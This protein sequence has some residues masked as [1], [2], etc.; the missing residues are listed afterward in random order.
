MDNFDL[1]E[2]IGEMMRTNRAKKFRKAIWM[3]IIV[4]GIISL[5]IL[6]LP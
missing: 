4:V 5:I 6:F 3:N 2:A 1:T